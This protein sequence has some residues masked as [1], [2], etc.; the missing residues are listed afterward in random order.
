MVP[1]T[2]FS[3]MAR[4]LTYVDECAP[5]ALAGLIAPAQFVAGSAIVVAGLATLISKLF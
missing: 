5:V 2:Y 4:L 3:D 1:P